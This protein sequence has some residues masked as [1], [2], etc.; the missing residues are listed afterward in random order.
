MSKVA[1]EVVGGVLNE[2]H[3]AIKKHDIEKAESLFEQAKATFDEMEE[4]Q[5]VLIY[6]SL[7]EEKG[8]G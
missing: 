4:N 3:L 2:L 6:F 5:D 1:S 7:L 8:I